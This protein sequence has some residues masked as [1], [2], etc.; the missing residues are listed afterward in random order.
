MTCEKKP[1][2][3]K[4][5]LM[6][7]AT[8]SIF[9]NYR[10]ADSAHTVGRIYDCL[11]DAFGP[12]AVFCDFDSIPKGAD[13][14]DSSRAVLADC[15][16]VLTVLGKD[17]LRILT[18]RNPPE[19]GAGPDW[20][21]QELE[22]AGRRREAEN[23][24][25]L[26]VYPLLLDTKMPPA[27][28]LPASLGWLSGINGDPVRIDP[29][30]HSDVLQVIRT[31]G[32]HL[33]V[34]PRVAA[35]AGGVRLSP[36]RKELDAIRWTDEL[37]T[38]GEGFVGREEELEAL[39]R[40]WADAR[41]RVVALW[42]DGGQGKTRLTVKWLTRVRDDGWRGA[43]P[44]LVHSF[45]SQGT[46]ERRNASS[47]LFFEQALAHF[48]YRGPPVTD[49]TERGRKLAALVADQN[50]LLVLDGLEPLQHPRSFGEGRLKDAAI[51][52]LLLSL[53][54]AAGGLCLV[55]SRQPVVELEDRSGAAVLQQ[56][57]DRLDPIVGSALLRQLAV[58]GPEREL[59]AAV[60]E[61]HGHAYSLML[62]GTYL[63]ETLD[64]DVRRR[65]EIPLLDEP[66]PAT[67]LP[68]HSRQM[69]RA[70]V[71]HLGDRS[72]E[73]AVL[74]LLGF[75]D[76]AAEMELIE[77]LRRGEDDRLGDVAAPLSDLS[78]RQWQRVLR[79]LE[80]LRLIH[81][82]DDALAG[83][84]SSSSSLTLRVSM[85]VGAIDSHALL[86][87]YFAEE[88]RTRFPAAWR[89]GHR[90][91]YEHLTTAT[92]RR[93][94]TIEGLQPLYQAVAHGCLAGLQ[95]QAREDVYDARILRGTGPGGFYSTKKLGA[96]G[97]D[98]GAVACF[99][100]DLWTTV[101]PN[102]TPAAQ[103][104]LLNEAAFRLRALGRLT[105]AVQ[106]MRAGLEAATDLD[107]WKNAA[108]RAGN[109]SELELTRGAV[110]AAVT[111]GQQSVTYADRSGDAFMRTVTRTTHADALHQAGRMDDAG[112]QFEEA[113][114]IQTKHQPAY[115]RLYS[116]QGFRYCDLLLS[117]AERAA[118]WATLPLTLRPAFDGASAKDEETLWHELQHVCV[119]VIEQA[120]QTLKWV[121]QDRGALLTIALNH[122]TLGRA[123][124]YR[125]IL[126]Q[127]EISNEEYQLADHLAAA[128]DGLRASGQ[129]DDLPRG[130]L[131]RAWLRYVSGDE[132]GSREDLDEAWEI[133]ER[134]PMPLF[135]VDVLLTRA[136]LFGRTKAEGSR[137]KG[138][139]DYPWQS[140]QHDLASARRLI[141]THGYHRRDQELADLDTESPPHLSL[142]H[143]I[144]AAGEAR[145]V[146]TTLGY[147]GRDQ[148]LAKLDT[149]SPPYLSLDHLIQVAR[150]A[151]DLPRAY[152]HYWERARARVQSKSYEHARW[153]YKQALKLCKSL[154]REHDVCEIEIELADLEYRS[155]LLNDAYVHLQHA[156][157]IMPREG[158]ESRL[159][160]IREVLEHIRKHATPLK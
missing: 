140:P 6:N 30:F 110:S 59:L 130:L 27:D 143:L 115:P 1:L 126:S 22:I 54:N 40:A 47:D 118:W 64:H 129:M 136:R 104:W 103:A 14:P 81:F 93:P 148:E 36:P 29:D 72:A 66:D 39:D 123:A 31:I 2:Q 52:A 65:G 131:T 75:F 96:I 4:R 151:K 153:D 20:V 60:E 82:H 109:L 76:R 145:G 106:P 26:L 24:G 158:N 71:A 101:S 28:D 159:T 78:P 86:R 38:Y 41:V 141:D 57:L 3:P 9:I 160:R 156:A 7:M 49:P 127:S 8:P 157:S 150:E 155:G 137:A 33:G 84:D 100:D 51:R 42:A 77:V 16:V 89:A 5:R 142:D 21:R 108:I 125:A 116:L 102:L 23:D 11:A 117:A 138:Q 25:R 139:P 48:G 35:P 91:F 111:A 146:L 53:A 68:D 17:W 19:G 144:Q 83:G 95:Q 128:V 70:Y 114:S 132:H 32:E 112:R 37:R 12:Q 92:E 154:D 34:T 10:R 94:D 62:L 134:G 97:A 55:T 135:R 88:L 58:R 124:L 73:V 119:A 67:R 99:F 149:A 80:E 63:G 147:Q 90:R 43:G 98:L 46:D 113:E 152:K 61:F 56:R 74:R 107:D 69:F 105:E 85:G 15:R 13:F 18:E 79:R 133:A 50:G 45:Y 44:V 122:L 120:T 121:E 87:E